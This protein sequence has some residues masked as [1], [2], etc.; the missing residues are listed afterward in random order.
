MKWFNIEEDANCPNWWT[1]NA[2][3]ASYNYTLLNDWHQFMETETP[4][5]YS[6]SDNALYQKDGC[7][8]VETGAVDE[9][10]LYTFEDGKKA[11]VDGQFIPLTSNGYDPAYHKTDEISRYY[12]CF[13]GCNWHPAAPYTG[14]SKA[15]TIHPEDEDL[16][17]IWFNNDWLNVQRDEPFFYTED[18]QTNV[19]TY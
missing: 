1:G 8:W 14:E 18:E 16:H 5:V 15:Y 17:Y 2:P 19:R 13:T 6:G 4:K 9:N 3:A 11:L 10:C 7:S 12:I